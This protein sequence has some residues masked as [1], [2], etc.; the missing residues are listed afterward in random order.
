MQMAPIAMIADLQIFN[1]RTYSMLYGY[2]QGL[3]TVWGCYQ[4]TVTIG[5]LLETLP[6]FY[7]CL[8]GAIEFLIPLDRPKIC[9]AEQNGHRGSNK[10]SLR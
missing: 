8:I 1:Q 4:T 3:N 9:C 2:C 6:L 7:L 10:R 5:L